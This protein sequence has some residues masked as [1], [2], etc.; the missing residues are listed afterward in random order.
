MMNFGIIKSRIEHTL[1]ESYRKGTFKEDMK[2]FKKLVLENKNISKLYYLY[3][4]LSSN[5]GLH[6]E[7]VNDYINESITIYENTLNKITGNEINKI[8]SWV[9]SPKIDNNYEVIDNLFSTNILAIENRIQSKKVIS[10]T[11]KKKPNVVKESVNIPLSTMVNVANKTITNYIDSLTESEK[12]ELTKLLSE[13][14]DKLEGEFNTIKE[15]VV[16]KLT[17]MRDSES[18]KS[19]QSRIEETLNKVISEKYDKLS[20]FKLKNLNE[21]I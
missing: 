13:N 15:S 16:S 11:L 8:I 19:T 9:G 20:Y 17:E 18:D 4:D 6:N 21:N 5:K 1:L 3:D 14:D 10:E 12:S 7:I 2:N